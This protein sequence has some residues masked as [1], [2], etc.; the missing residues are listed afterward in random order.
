LVVSGKVTPNAPFA[1]AEDLA[2]RLGLLLAEVVRRH[3]DHDQAL[4]LIALP[5][6]SAALRIAA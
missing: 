6:R 4:G 1:E 3:A 2:F 5:Q